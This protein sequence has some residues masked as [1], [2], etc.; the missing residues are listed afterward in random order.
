MKKG[1]FLELVCCTRMY[2]HE[3][4]NKLFVQVVNCRCKYFAM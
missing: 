4:Q 2:L 3:D 1:I